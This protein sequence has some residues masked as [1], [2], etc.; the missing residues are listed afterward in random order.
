MPGRLYRIPCK[1]GHVILL[2]GDA[3]GGVTAAGP[4]APTAPPGRPAP[5]GRPP[6]AA[7]ARE[8]DVP[9]FDGDPFAAAVA[10]PAHPA[11]TS[12]ADLGLPGAWTDARAKPAVAPVPPL[13]LEEPTPPSLRQPYPE[14]RAFGGPE[15]G[16][17]LEPLAGGP[18]RAPDVPAPDDPFAGL[19]ASLADV[20]APPSPEP[21]RPS[22]VRPASL[23]PPPFA[24]IERG[25][26][27]G[28]A[29][30]AP[31]VAARV[32]T[33]RSRRGL[34]VAIAVGSAAAGAVGAWLF[35]ISRG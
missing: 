9:Q 3:S 1:C 26:P 17:D 13:R 29:P 23:E 21:P 2:R 6:A 7:P 33:R 16:L 5:S 32:R 15:D 18:P 11:A 34:L 12:A 22:V 19:A 31:S 28:A 10:Q 27:S 4:A 35:V 14:P 8:V 25:E 24:R 30:A 20:K